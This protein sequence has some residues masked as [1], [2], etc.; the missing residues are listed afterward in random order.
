MGQRTSISAMTKNLKDDYEGDKEPYDDG[1]D[2]ATAGK[3][4]NGEQS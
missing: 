3:V 4:D 1:D 2:E